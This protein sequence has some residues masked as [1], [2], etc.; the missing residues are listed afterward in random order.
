MIIEETPIAGLKVIRFS[1]IRDERGY[2][3]RTFCS[4]DFERHGL[5]PTIAQA[6]LAFSYRSGTTRGMHFQIPPTAETK[7]VR[8]TRG[9]IQDVVVDLRPE[10][11]TFLEHFELELTSDNGT[12]LYVPE[13]FAHGYQTL[14][15][16]VE[17]AYEVGAF[18]T[19]NCERGLRFDDPRLALPWR[20]RPTSVSD[21]DRNWPLLEPDRLALLR[22]EL[23]L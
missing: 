22:K 1:L 8:C 7:L 21:K 19:P 17:V 16:D 12:A 4:R 6:N 9:A 14:T 20:L 11:P 23:G 13:R 15:D 3:A 5:K 18:Y 10:S 2:F